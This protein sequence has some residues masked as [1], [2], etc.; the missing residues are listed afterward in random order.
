MQLWLRDWYE[1]VLPLNSAP[2]YHPS[3]VHD[4]PVSA[5]GPSAMDVRLKKV[6]RPKPAQAP[7]AENTMENELLKKLKKRQQT[8][9]V[10][11]QESASY[12]KTPAESTEPPAQPSLPLPQPEAT[13]AEVEKEKSPPPVSRV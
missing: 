5:P 2:R 8:I 9:E 3:P 11:E 12:E 1:Y 6:E 10:A 13:A 7:A 4:P